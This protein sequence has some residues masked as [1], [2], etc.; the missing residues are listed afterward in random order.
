[1][2]LQVNPTCSHSEFR[3]SDMPGGGGW[4]WGLGDQTLPLSKRTRN[5]KQEAVEKQEARV[6]RLGSGE[7]KGLRG[8]PQ[9]RAEGGAEDWSGCGLV[10]C[11][12]LVILL[13]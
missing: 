4:S 8:A 12:R 7:G 10:L 1:M 3:V 5:G 2:K 13:F 9:T 11:G 6:F